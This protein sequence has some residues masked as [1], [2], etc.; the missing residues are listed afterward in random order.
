MRMVEVDEVPVVLSRSESGEVCAIEAACT[1]RG[2]PLAEGEREEDA[3]GTARGSTCAPERR[4]G[5]RRAYR[6]S[7]SRSGCATAG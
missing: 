5:C 4:C 1:H 3:P 2:G 7:A 6:S